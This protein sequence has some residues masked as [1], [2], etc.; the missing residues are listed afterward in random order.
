MKN[1]K[2]S[3]LP[4]N[5]VIGKDGPNYEELYIKRDNGVWEDLFAGCGCCVDREKISD[6]GCE[7]DELYY[8]QGGMTTTKT[9]D[10]YFEDF[11]VI[12]L[13]PGFVFVGDAESI[14]GP[15]LDVLG[16]YSDGTRP[17]ECKGYNCAQ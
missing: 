4:E 7:K 15:L 1:L 8:S 6:D 9:S 13:P 14:H 12:S 16:G 10:E 2:P 3:Q 11:K 17:H 5:T